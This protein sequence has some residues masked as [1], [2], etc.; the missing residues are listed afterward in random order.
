VLLCLC[1]DKLENEYDRE[2]GFLHKERIK[3]L[4]ETEKALVKENKND[5]ASKNLLAKTRNLI[6]EELKRN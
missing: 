4:I 2:K 1:K 6:M 3:F 5:S